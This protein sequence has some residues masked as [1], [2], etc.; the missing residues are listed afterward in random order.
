MPEQPIADAVDNKEVLLL[1]EEIIRFFEKEASLHPG[2]FGFRNLCVN[3]RIEG[4]CYGSF[5]THTF[6]TGYFTL[7]GEKYRR[8][9]CELVRLALDHAMDISGKRDATHKLS[10][11]LEGNLPCNGDCECTFTNF[12]FEMKEI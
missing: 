3:V 5:V 7:F 1:S 2:R 12:G 6:P 10:W 9:S 8:N 11:K 4:I